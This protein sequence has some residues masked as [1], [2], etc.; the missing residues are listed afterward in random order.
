MDDISKNIEEYN[1]NK[2]R[3]K[4]IVFDDIFPDILSDKSLHQQLNYLLEVENLTFLL[5]LFHNLTFLCQEM[6]ELIFTHC[7][8]MKIPNKQEPQQI[9]FNHSSDIEFKDFKNLYIK[10]TS[11]P[12]SFSVIDATLSPDNSSSFRIFKK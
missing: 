4:L 5:I 9:L 11:K 10:G 3:K 8:I 7:F 6:L 1:H 12:H 2:K